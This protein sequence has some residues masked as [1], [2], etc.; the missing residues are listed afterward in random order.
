MSNNNNSRRQT[1]ESTNQ[2]TKRRALDRA[3]EQPTIRMSRRSMMRATAG[4]SAAAI[5]LGA[6]IT[7]SVAGNISEFEDLTI[8][9]QNRIVN[10]SGEPFKM[11]G[12]SIPDPKR[13]DRTSQLRGKTPLQLLDMMTNND[14]GWY[15][16]AIRLPAQPQ[17]IGEHPMGHAGPEYFDDDGNLRPEAPDI[18]NP[19]AIRDNRRAMQPPQPVA[20]TESELEDYLE[21]YYDPLVERCKERGVYAIVDFHRHWHEQPPGTE[22]PGAAENHLPYDSPYTNYWAY[23]TYEDQYVS[24]DETTPASWGHVD[25]TYINEG[26]HQYRD[27]PDEDWAGIE[28]DADI[29]GTPYE[30]DNWQVNEELLEEALLFWSVVADRYA[31][32]PHV[33]FEPYNEPTA[34]GIWGPV[35]GC[36]ALKQEPLWETFVDDFMGPIIDEIR[37]HQPE[38]VLL[39]GVPGWCQSLQGLYWYD[40]NDAGYDN[41]AVTWHNYAGHD[42]SQLNNWFNDTNYSW[43]EDI[44]AE[45]DGELTD[46]YIEPDQDVYEDSCYGWEGYEAAGLQDAMDFHHISISEFGWI[47]D[48]EVAHW[49]RGTTTGQGTLPEYGIPFF[50][51]I[52][53][54]D[55]ISWIAWCADVRWYPTMFEFPEGPDEGDLVDEVLVNDNFYDTDLE[56]IWA[57]LP[58]GAPCPDVEDQPCEWELLGGEDSGEYIKEQ[59]EVHR[60]DLVPFDL[61]TTDPGYDDPDLYN[62]EPSEGIQVGEY[63]AQDT[64]DDG[65]HNDFTGDGETTHDD[66]TAFFENF[67]DDGVQDNPEAFDFTDSG[68]VT[69]SDVA[70]L[71][72]QL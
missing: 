42:V 2:S 1:G 40:F 64:T 32:E 41:I 10:E 61:G 55:R 53:D 11:R 65:L 24:F 45:T 5:G 31:D 23:N 44:A 46:P 54:D 27:N 48:P 43:H 13:L 36:G 34:P 26:D 50:D 30:Y 60:D 9:S 52:E 33:V 56:D 18:E 7:G 38:Q 66:V 28:T 67:E 3:S 39:V 69:F 22:D 71:L 12:V 49:L 4:A 58:D 29:P 72:R 19:D 70:E 47:D 35:E 6:G 62:G 21:N 51:Q 57:A 15:P 37:Q 25:S 63:T 68:D 17:D 8:D 59:L 16:R 20:F 14:R